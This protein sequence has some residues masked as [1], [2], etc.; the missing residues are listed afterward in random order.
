M[1]FPRVFVERWGVLLE[2]LSIFNVC[3]ICK[4]TGGS[5]FKEQRQ[6]SA[7]DRCNSLC[8]AP[9]EQQETLMLFRLSKLR[10]WDCGGLWG[11]LLF[12]VFTVTQVADL[13]VNRNKKF[14][15]F[16]SY[17][18]PQSPA[19]SILFK[20][21]KDILWSII[22]RLPL[23]HDSW[24]GFEMVFKG[25]NLSK[26]SQKCQDIVRECSIKEYWLSFVCACVV[27]D[28]NAS[29][30]HSARPGQNVQRKQTENVQCKLFFQLPFELFSVSLN[31]NQI[32]LFSFLLCSCVWKQ[33][34]ARE[35]LTQFHVWQRAC[36]SRNIE[37]GPITAKV[38]YVLYYT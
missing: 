16:L 7:M 34:V 18:L 8:F 30:K 13:H 37:W 14:V 10:Q 35:I 19:W 3:R 17:C 9:Q 21:P 4:R 22:L 20:A 1:L 12:C 5:L 24:A 15:V 38:K 26:G 25:Q 23:G 2:I 27:D 28:P 6:P 11:F 32:L 36:Y 31:N 29:G 33:V